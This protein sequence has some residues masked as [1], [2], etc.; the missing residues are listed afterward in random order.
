M[1]PTAECIKELPNSLS[2]WAVTIAFVW[3]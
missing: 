1:L 2:V 3:L